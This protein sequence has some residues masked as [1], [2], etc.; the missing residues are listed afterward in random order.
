[1]IFINYIRI[2]NMSSEKKRK[3]VIVLMTPA[4]E[5]T[6]GH[7]ELIL[8]FKG[9]KYLKFIDVHREFCD[10][11]TKLKLF[12]NTGAITDIE[13]NNQHIYLHRSGSNTYVDLDFSLIP[14]EL[15]RLKQFFDEMCKDVILYQN[16]IFNN[17]YFNYIENKKYFDEEWI[18]FIEDLGI[19]TNGV[20]DL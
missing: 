8:R 9:K 15:E 13:H 12:I 1:M 19:I 5:V 17:G 4:I 6:S 10:I 20:K 14:R 18:N 2:N 16:D 7:G 11:S 3:S